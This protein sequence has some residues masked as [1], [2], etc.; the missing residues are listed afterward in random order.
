MIN[1]VCMKILEKGNE[2][3]VLCSIINHHS[4]GCFKKK[5]ETL[6]IFWTKKTVNDRYELLPFYSV[7]Y[8]K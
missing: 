7:P 3:M 8:S 4:I 5:W 2:K 6:H 1:R